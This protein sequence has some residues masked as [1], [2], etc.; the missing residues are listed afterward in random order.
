MGISEG[1]WVTLET[2]PK[3]MTV[4]PRP[5]KARVH[6]S[7]R[8]ARKDCVITF[9]GL[10]HRSPKLRYAKSFGYRDGDLIPQKDPNI[11]K[12]YD[13]TGMGWVEDVYVSIKKGGRS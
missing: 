13:P 12:K 1:D 5:V 6:I 4:L 11:V 2:N 8:V 7:S 3:Y 10:G 9:H